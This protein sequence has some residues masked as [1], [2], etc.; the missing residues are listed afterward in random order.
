M[1]KSLIAVALLWRFCRSPGAMQV[2]MA[3]EAS[4]HTITGNLTLASSY[5]FRG[6]DQ[7]LRQADLQGASTIPTPA[8]S[9]RQLE[10]QRFV[11]CRL[12]RRQPGN[13]LLWWLSH[14]FW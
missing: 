2:A 8:V 4:P 10:L 1:K 3:D 12:C 5:R 13:G 6:I 11:G 7:T 14:R 9:T